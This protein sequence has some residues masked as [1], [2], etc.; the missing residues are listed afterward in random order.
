MIQ[1]I[2]SVWLFLASLTLF[3][4]LI[5]PILT[6]SGGTGDIWVQIGGLYQKTNNISQKIESNNTLFGATILLSLLCFGNIFTFKNRSL[7]KRIILL[8]I[9]LIVL[10]AAF[11]ANYVVNI[12]GGI[13]GA[14]F[15]AGAYSPLAAILFCTLAFSGIR[16]D[17]QLIRS[18]DRLR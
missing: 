9:F 17:E 8:S 14:T 15:G 4:L 1:R 2:Q 7:Q 12:P 13:E 3:L 10:L 11:T 18:A 6:K 16:K 5:L